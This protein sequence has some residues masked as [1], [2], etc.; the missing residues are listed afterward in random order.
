MY[1]SNSRVDLG[2]AHGDGHVL[3]TGATGL[4]GAELVR[5]WAKAGTVRRIAVLVRDRARWD[6]VACRLALSDD[7]VVALEGDVTREGLGLTHDAR[8]WLARHATAMV[9]LAAD[10]TFSRPLDQARL[11]NRDGTAHLLA[12]AADCPRV[13]RVAF[14]STAFVAGRRT[15]I[16]AESDDGAATAQIGWVNAYEQSKAEAEALVRS[17]RRDWVILRSSTI[18]CDDTSGVVTQRNAV[19]QALRLFHDGLAAMIPGVSDSVLDV[20]P[21]DYVADAIARLALR[22]DLDGA[23]VQ[24]CAGA[25][26]MPLGE[27]LDECYARWATDA[28]WRRRRIA[29]PSQGDLETWE[30][31]TQAVEETGHPRLRRVTRALAHFLPQ[32]ALPK[33]FDTRRADA[34]LGA[35]APPVHEYWGR[36]IDHLQQTGWRGVPGLAEVA[37]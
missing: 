14:V 33:R 8:T 36:M 1:T 20:V 19:H 7:A 17:A 9:H 24:L 3:V 27:L 5:R 30:M 23:T 29:P 16:V 32:L 15:G 35:A 31:F 21:A 37:A 25:G 11:V 13:A 10:T 4:L 26:A 12:L 28:T 18:A 6:A 2:A 22:R 34:L